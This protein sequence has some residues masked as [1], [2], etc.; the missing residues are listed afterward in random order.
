MGVMGGVGVGGM[1]ALNW[2]LAST[3][4]STSQMWKMMGGDRQV[5]IKKPRGQSREQENFESRDISRGRKYPGNNFPSRKEILLWIWGMGI[6][7]QGERG[8]KPS[9]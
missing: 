4:W 7:R 3:S 6:A 2:V 8:E 5:D 9:P 1:R